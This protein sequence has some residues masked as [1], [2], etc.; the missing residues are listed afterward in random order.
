VNDMKSVLGLALDAGP[1]AG[2]AA[3][4]D[5]DLARGRRLLRR[6]R[7]I[8]AAGVAAAMVVGATVPFAL[9]NSTV[10]ASHPVAGIHR[11]VVKTAKPSASASASASATGVKLVAWTGTQ[12]PGYQ[13]N[14]MPSGW[15]VQGS[16]PFALVIAPLG[17]TDTNADSF[18]GKLVVMLQSASAS[19]PPPGSSQPV[20]GRPGVFETAAQAGGDTEILD[21]KNA[22]GQ[23][24][25]V[26]APMALGWDSAQLAQF[27]GGV[28]VLAAAQPGLG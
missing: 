6:R 26:Q 9:R 24:V 18:S 10:P 21:F 19:S 2:A 22:N 27:C 1:A 7:M 11:P 5:Q 20:N 14:W 8:G 23:W 16:T 25:W 13:V 3:D 15:V 28:T 4:P 12:P 17:D